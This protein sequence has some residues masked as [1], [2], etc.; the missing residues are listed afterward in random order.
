MTAEG[1][2]HEADR[3]GAAPPVPESGVRRLARLAAV[4]VGPLRRHRDYR[5]L[6]IG[7]AV[8]YFGS[9]ITYVAVPYQIY[10]LTGSTAVVGL[11]A[12]AELAPLLLSAVVGG[13]FADAV[14]RR[15]MVLLTQVGLCL[16]S[17]L[18]V[19]NALLPH[20]QVWV[21]FV[22]AAIAA[23]LIGFQRPSLDALTPRLVER[24]ELTAAGAL[25]TLRFNLGTIAG[26]AIGGVLIAAIGLPGVFGLDVA[27]FL[28]S[29]VLLSLMRTVPPPADAERPSLHRIAEGF[30]YARSRPELLGTYGV[31]MAAM[32]FGMPNAL[33]PALADGFGG[34]KALGLL[35]AAPE[36][37]SLLATA[38]SGWTSR[39]HRHG[40][41]VLCAAGVWG[42]GILLLGLAPNLPLALCALG[43][44]GGADMVSGI[45]RMT[46][47]N[48][49]I[50]DRLR[51]RLAGIEQVSYSSG[52]LL[53]DVEAGV[54]G[55]LAGVR[56]SIVSGGILCVVAV[57]L[58][59]V[60]LP[61]FRAYD[62]RSPVAEPAAP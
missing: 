5:L 57:G 33:F 3:L 27:T 13:A 50:P 14:D 43:L 40:L 21:L 56:T 55:S 2:L 62:A 58:L 1:P 16:T 36:V 28:V 46:I 49:T 44:A 59:A 30:R 34:A 25:D 51:G 12:L 54:V 37:G 60:L 8:S 52:P 32:F 24:D 41:G 38:T 19:V 18:L 45:F 61:A 26:P 35:Y 11:V 53:G 22:V 7:L 10:R 29:L 20:P 4:D 23:S 47:W 31:D 15:R 6:W 39:V 17:G 9:E 42:V 48:Q